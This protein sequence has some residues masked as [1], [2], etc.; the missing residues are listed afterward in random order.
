MG[1]KLRS[2][3]ICRKPACVASDSLSIS[4][5]NSVPPAARAST[6]GL[7]LMAPVNAPRFQPV[8]CA[9]C[10]SAGTA[11]KS[12][13]SNGPA[14]RAERAWHQRASR[15]LPAPVGPAMSK[16]SS[17]EANTL[18]SSMRLAVLTPTTGKR[19]STSSGCSGPRGGNMRMRGATASSSTLRL[20]TTSRLGTPR[21][22]QCEACSS[23]HTAPPTVAPSV[24]SGNSNTCVQSR[25]RMR[26]MVGPDRL[27]AG[28]VTMNSFLP[29]SEIAAESCTS[30]TNALPRCAIHCHA[31][32][33][34]RYARA[35]SRVGEPGSSTCTKRTTSRV[36]SCMPARR[37]LTP[38]VPARLAEA[39]SSARMPPSTALA[40]SSSARAWV[41][42]SRMEPIHESSFTVLAYSLSLG[43]NARHCIRTAK[44]R[45]GHRVGLAKGTYLCRATRRP[46][47]WALLRSLWS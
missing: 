29:S 2:S 39:S 31:A 38:V 30:I 14:A 3:R 43:K 20:C 12:S 7:S 33:G 17:E 16:V 15:D 4:S 47:T 27:S 22:T 13:S 32:V 40:P 25:V 28:S 37:N 9:I 35:T 1:R 19:S 10:S 36:R 42:A 23:I 34:G 6:P 5:M 21:P 26:S 18:S 8:I 11:I 24:R 46:A 41:T 44:I 45:V